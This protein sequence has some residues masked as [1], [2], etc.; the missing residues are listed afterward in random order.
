ML[1]AQN[2]TFF[3]FRLHNDKSSWVMTAILHEGRI[4]VIN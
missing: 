4:G 2:A 1:V 3:F